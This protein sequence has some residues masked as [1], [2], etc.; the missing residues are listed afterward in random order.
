MKS[1]QIMLAAAMLV[2]AV[3]SFAQSTP[4]ALNGDVRAQLVQ[5][6]TTYQSSDSN[7]Q[8]QLAINTVR[9]NGGQSRQMAGVNL[10]RYSMSVVG[11]AF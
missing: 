11:P 2:P 3:S 6:K 5:E 9:R 7:E 4:P 1:I 10:G 8:K